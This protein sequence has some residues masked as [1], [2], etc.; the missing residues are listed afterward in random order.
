M[1]NIL[2]IITIR[3]DNCVTVGTTSRG[4]EAKVNSEVLKYDVKI[5]IGAIVP[6]PIAGF[7]GGCKIILPGVSAIETIYKNHQSSFE[8]VWFDR[9]KPFSYH[10]GNL[11]NVDMREDAEEVAMLM[12]LNYKVDV[13]LNTRC[14]I[15]DVFAGHPII[16]YYEGVKKAFKVY[17]TEHF[18]PVD[19]CILNANSKQNE[20]FMAMNIG[21]DCIKDGGDLVIVNFCP[22]GIVNHYLSTMW[23]LHTGGSLSLGNKDKE[24]LPAKIRKMIIFSTYRQYTTTIF[25][26]RTEQVLWAKTWEEV[27]ELLGNRRAKIKAAVLMDALLEML[28][29]PFKLEY[30]PVNIKKNSILQD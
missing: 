7:S 25:Y 14:E 29:D 22:T 11:Q 13:M 12:G 3:Y 2:F 6:H 27:L 9:T 23:G 21:M 5:A 10:Y 4:I 17:A 1:R 28:S 30:E 15:I 16:E 18:D 24:G 8:K 20:A 26:G 19:V